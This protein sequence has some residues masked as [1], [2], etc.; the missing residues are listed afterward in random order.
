V[1]FS[2]DIKVHL[3]IE[4]VLVPN[5]LLQPI[6]ENSIKHGYSKKN[7][8]LSLFIK[9]SKCDDKIEFIINNNGKPL[10]QS[11]NKITESGL[12]IKNTVERLKHYI[13]KITFLI[14]STMI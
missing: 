10:N 7:L 8:K 3:D 12:G 4:N 2:E 9:I 1:R 13:Q 11:S 5:M 14:Y 6:V